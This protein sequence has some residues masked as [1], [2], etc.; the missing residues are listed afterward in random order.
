MVHRASSAF[1]EERPEGG[2]SEAP[3][4]TKGVGEPLRRP[5]KARSKHDERIDEFVHTFHARPAV[6]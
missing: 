6:R 4:Q 1:A 2:E 3:K 5:E